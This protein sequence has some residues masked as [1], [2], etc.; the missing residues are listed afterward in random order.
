MNASS[1]VM[2]I[3]KFLLSLGEILK[4]PGFYK[5]R[6]PVINQSWS[7]FMISREV[8]IRVG[9][10]D[11]RFPAIGNEDEDYESRLGFKTS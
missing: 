6:L 4:N 8:I 11:E 5:K 7:H 3:W 2:M 1:F 9:W 10:F